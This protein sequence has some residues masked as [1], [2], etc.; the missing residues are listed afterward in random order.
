MA[1]R[2]SSPAFSASLNAV[3]RSC[4]A[5]EVRFNEAFELPRLRYAI[6]IIR[7]K[8]YR[9]IEILYR[10]GVLSQLCL[11]KPSIIVCLASSGFKLYCLIVI[12][13]RS[14]VLSQVCLRSSPIIVCYGMIW[15]K[16]YRLIEIAYRSKVLSQLCLRIAPIDIKLYALSAAVYCPSFLFAK[17]Y[18]FIVA[19]STSFIAAVYRPNSAFA[20]PR[21]LYASASIGFKLYCL[22]VI[23]YRSGVLSQLCLRKSSI[24]VCIGIIWF[25]LYRLIVIP[26][27]SNV[28]TKVILRK[29]PIVVCRGIIRFELY[30]L[31]EIAYRSGVLSQLCLR[32]SPIDCMP[33]HN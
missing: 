25:E 5:A 23:T 1:L 7:F 10:S 8:L 32:K 30:R 19:L 26:Y 4:F 17:L 9:F 22:I 27:R 20:T 24:V 11:R 21:L 18:R 33:W 14:K 13:Y 2:L 3:R 29:S 6:G 15:F 28:L 12:L 31:I 16:L